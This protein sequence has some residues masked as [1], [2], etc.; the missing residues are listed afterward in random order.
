MITVIG[1]NE[2][3]FKLNDNSCAILLEPRKYHDSSI[4][5]YNKK[6]DRFMYDMYQ[7]IE[8]LSDQGM[9][10]EE[11]Y[12]WFSFNTLGTYV[13]NYPIFLDSEDD[14]IACFSDDYK[15]IDNDWHKEGQQ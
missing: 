5:G 13:S 2:K 8:Q 4:I 12:E 7:F 14:S 1:A 15:F 10:S 9:S 3:E 6:E 11:A